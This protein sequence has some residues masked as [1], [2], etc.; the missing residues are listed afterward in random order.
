MDPT[1]EVQSLYRAQRKDVR[2]SGIDE[3]Q[4][5]RAFGRYVEFVKAHVPSGARL[6]DVGCG[7][8]WSTWLLA[9]AGYRAVGVDLNPEAFE[10]RGDG[11]SFI[12]GSALD[13]PLA[14][15]SFDAVC[16]HEA[17]EHVPRPERALDEMLRVLRPGGAI[18]VVGPN[19]LSPVLSLRGIFV[20]AWRNRPLRTIF[21]RAPGMPRH[22]G[23]NTLPE[24]I[25]MLFYRLA[26]IG[27]KSLGS[28]ATFTL[29]E[30]DRRP[31][32]HSDNDACYLLNPIDVVKHLRA[33]GCTI[34]RVGFLG[35][36][37]GTALL[38]GG[39]WIAARKQP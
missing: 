1:E 22:P 16:V 6:L 33:R 26:L 34:A 18:V 38:A 36:P 14:S 35:R 9:R 24:S 20:N 27:K 15:A 12:A 10:K 17:L 4:A 11:A 8:G 31:P 28:R 21:F 3:P 29:R 25:G 37:P 13:L 32:F 19:L 39:T 23:G 5:E 2:L 30:P 7:S